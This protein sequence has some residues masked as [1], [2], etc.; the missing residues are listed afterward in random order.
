LVTQL[1]AGFERTNIPLHSSEVAFRLYEQKKYL[2]L[3]GATPKSPGTL[4]TVLDSAEEYRALQ[5]QSLFAEELPD[6]LPVFRGRTVANFVARE[7]HSAVL[8]GVMSGAPPG[9][10]HKRRHEEGE[11][12]VVSAASS[13]G[14]A[15]GSAGGL[16][17]ADL[18]EANKALF[19]VFG[20]Q[21]R[22]ELQPLSDRLTLVEK[23]CQGIAVLDSR[24]TALETRGPSSRASSAAGSASDHPPG[25]MFA[26]HPPG[27]GFAAASAASGPPRVDPLQAHDPWAR[28][29][30]AQGHVSAEAGTGYANMAGN[31]KSNEHT[32]M[33]RVAEQ[34]HV[35]DA[36]ILRGWGTFDESNPASKE[37]CSVLWEKLRAAL[38]P[39][40][41]VL[42]GSPKIYREN[43]KLV[44]PVAAGVDNCR[45]VITDL[46]RVCQSADLGVFM[47]KQLRVVPDSTPEEKSA[48][49]EIGRMAGA[50][51]EWLGPELAV[52]IRINWGP[53]GFI[54]FDSI[55]IGKIMPDLTWKWLPRNIL[56]ATKLPEQRLEELF[57]R[58]GYD[59]VE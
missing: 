13:V 26:A 27:P 23:Q 1:S 30:T 16:T 33:H 49:S 44:V 36:V 20:S 34:D 7:T 28:H 18:A 25:H 12:E 59:D 5:S 11:G 22:Q 42:V 57:M 2:R 56:V 15:A 47:G 55:V 8:A 43:Y 48:N 32:H 6:T 29:K 58:C 31:I 21:L 19:E 40:V 45:A 4:A 39:E 41:V 46:E 52:R 50:L 17:R 54:R 3:S 38:R 37:A 53:R 51:R 24:I 14:G 9:Q 10:A 35:P